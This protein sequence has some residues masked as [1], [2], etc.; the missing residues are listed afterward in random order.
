MHREN[1]RHVILVK[2]P[3]CRTTLAN[4][5]TLSHNVKTFGHWGDGS[6]VKMFATQA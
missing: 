6:M 5:M 1:M 3:V 2:M 4:T